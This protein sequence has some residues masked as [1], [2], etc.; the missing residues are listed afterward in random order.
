M[1]EFPT[2]NVMVILVVTVILDMGVDANDI[3]HWL[4]QLSNEKKGPNGC[5]RVQNKG[6]NITQLFFQEGL[7][8][9]HY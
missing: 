1:L 6:W 4:F 7:Y 2:K 8:L 9:T 5:F 3:L